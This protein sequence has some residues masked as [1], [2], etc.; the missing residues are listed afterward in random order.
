MHGFTPCSSSCGSIVEWRYCH[1]YTS[2][3]IEWSAKQ[4]LKKHRRY[5]NH[6]LP[7]FWD[8]FQ[9]YS[10]FPTAT[11][12]H[13]RVITFAHFTCFRNE[14][15]AGSSI[16]NCNHVYIC[17][18]DKPWQV[19]PIINCKEKVVA[20]EW[21]VSGYRLLIATSLGKVQIWSMKVMQKLLTWNI[22]VGMCYG[23]PL[24]YSWQRMGLG[25]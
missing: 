15:R 9:F 5:Q 11:Y 8:N 2:Q 25:Q 22:A 16:G 3:A 1:H 14:L 23:L 20:L 18:I 19:Y 21:H 13:L 17:D 4:I 7:F 12:I 24:L 10:E 6:Y